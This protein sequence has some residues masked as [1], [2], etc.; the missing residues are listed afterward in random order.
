V[1]EAT[2]LRYERLADRQSTLAVWIRHPNAR[3]V[4][5]GCGRLDRCHVRIGTVRVGPTERGS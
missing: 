1:S 2:V 5:M 3:S 4:L